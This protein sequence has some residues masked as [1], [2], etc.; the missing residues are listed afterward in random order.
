MTT[1][2][3]TRHIF[4]V[5]CHR[6][7]TTQC[8]CFYTGCPSNLRVLQ[9]KDC[10]V[11]CSPTTPVLGPGLGTHRVLR[12]HLTNKYSRQQ[13]ARAP[14]VPVLRCEKPFPLCSWPNAFQRA[15]EGAVFP[16]SSYVEAL[17]LPRPHVMVL[18][19]GA[20]GRWS[21]VEVMRVGLHDTG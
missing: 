10:I 6:L 7:L 18:G 17:P 5:F 12:K 9:G 11:W 14:G 15:V 16:Q 2:A 3:P 1:V 8:S 20:F 19:G 21:A 13:A 4:S